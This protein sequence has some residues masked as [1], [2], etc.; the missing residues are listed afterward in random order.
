MNYAQLAFTDAVKDLQEKKGSRRGY[1]RME[2]MSVVDGLTDNEI[3]FIEDRDS[4]YIAS[5]GENEYPYI[6]HR[7]GPKGFI[8]VIDHKTIGF[9]DFVGNK[10]YISTGNIVT[11]NNVA[12]IMM[13]YPHQARLKL[14]AKAKIV[15]LENDQKL[16]ELLQPEDYKFRPERMMV[17]EIQAYDWNCPQHITQRYTSQEIDEALMPQKEYIGNLENKVKIL[18]EKLRIQKK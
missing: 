2:K 11:N 13:S 10:Q 4:F 9:V 6:Q 17:F 8:K 7:G 1:D 12:I 15:D 3:Y 16:Y 18:E 5:F 14:Y